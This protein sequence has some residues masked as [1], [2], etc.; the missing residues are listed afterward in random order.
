MTM[1]SSSSEQLAEKANIQNPDAQKPLLLQILEKFV[2][3]DVQPGK[4]KSF[5]D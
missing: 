3:G 2:D 4:R 1:E 5:A